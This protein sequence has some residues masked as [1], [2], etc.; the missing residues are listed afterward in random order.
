MYEVHYIQVSWCILMSQDF[1]REKDKEFVVGVCNYSLKTELK[2]HA[3]VVYIE[4]LTVC[5]TTIGIRGLL[6]TG[7]WWNN[8]LCFSVNPPK[9]NTL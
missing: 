4:T 5:S 3:A 1:Q 2:F 7:L 8:L 9:C 6:H